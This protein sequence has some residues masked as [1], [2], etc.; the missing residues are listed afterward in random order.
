MT[1][2]EEIQNSLKDKCSTNYRIN[3]I[4]LFN[5]P[6]YR[7]RTS[8]LVNNMPEKTLNEIYKVFIKCI[9]SGINSKR[10]LQ[11]FLGLTENDF[12]WKELYELR[13]KNLIDLDH[14]RWTVT[15]AG[16][17]YIDGKSLISNLQENDCEFLI[18]GLNGSLLHPEKIIPIDAWKKVD[19][20]F[21]LPNSH[22]DFIETN[23]N[24]LSDVHKIATNNESYLVSYIS[25]SKIKFSRLYKGLVLVEYRPSNPNK[26]DIES[27]IEVRESIPPFR[28]VQD[29]T[30]TLSAKYPEIIYALT[31][32]EREIAQITLGTDIDVL[33]VQAIEDRHSWEQFE[34]WKGV[35][36]FE[37][38]IKSAVK[39]LY[40][41]MPR[42][43]NSAKHYVHL[44]ELALERNVQVTFVYGL[45]NYQNDSELLLRLKSLAE[46]FPKKLYLV[47][48][49]IHLKAV[50]HSNYNGTH[51]RVLIKDNDY[52][53]LSTF[54]F[55]A[56]G[57]KGNQRVANED[58][59]VN[60]SNVNKERKKIFEMYQLDM[61]FL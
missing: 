12:L 34:L 8:F 33:S 37:Q 7:L 4:I 25:G 36:L 42:V 55:F 59:L 57:K 61:F 46:R 52:I 51:R 17:D 48:L 44:I 24:N 29:A 1:L 5:Y 60:R 41:E 10:A 19:F 27:Y 2:R 26:P 47:D 6:Y 13:T 30:K 31:D 9:D 53:I 50:D 38:S 28:K 21:S 56:S 40:I 23:F 45:D 20:N 49:P 18:D 54:N 32:S 16:R 15:Q 3:E 22:E 43:W 58:V 11:T 39:K 35:E 14:D